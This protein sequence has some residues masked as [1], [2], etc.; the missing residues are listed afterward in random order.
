[1]QCRRRGFNPWVGKIPWRRKW[2]PTPVFLPGKSHGQSSLA[3]YSLRGRKESDTTEQLTRYLTPNSAFL[4][5]I[6][7]LEEAIPGPSGCQALSLVPWEWRKGHPCGVLWKALGFSHWQSGGSS[8]D[9]LCSQLRGG[10]GLAL[11]LSFISVVTLIFLCQTGIS[12]ITW[13][14]SPLVAP[15]Q[16]LA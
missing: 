8:G 14:G 2:Q 4:P 6:L 10:P 5:Y 16:P 13:F 11:P 12:L 1:M 9:L 3:G 15:L 7:L